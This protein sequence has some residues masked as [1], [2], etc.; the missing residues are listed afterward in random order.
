MRL[1]G[2]EAKRSSSP[3]CIEARYACSNI[4]TGNQLRRDLRTWLS[5]PDPSTNHNIACAAHH[6]GTATWFF[7]G[8]IYNEWKSTPSLLWI[9]GKRESHPTPHLTPPNGILRVAGSGK[10]ILWFVDHVLFLSKMTDIVYHLPVLRLS[11]ISKICAMPVK[12]RWVIS[13]S[14]FGTS[15]N[16]TGV[17]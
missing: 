11:K 15:A 8:S 14:T 16:N 3:N 4:L 10:S 9:H 2:Q 7:Q 13:I 5:P 17:T 12:P 6:R 1:V